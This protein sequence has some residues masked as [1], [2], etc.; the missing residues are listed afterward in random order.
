MHNKWIGS[1]ATDVHRAPWF[2]PMAASLSTGKE[3]NNKVSNQ[4]YLVNAH[5]RDFY[6]YTRIIVATYLER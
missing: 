2:A 6:K 1:N 4:D 5:I 3:K